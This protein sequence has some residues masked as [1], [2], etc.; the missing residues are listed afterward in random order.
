MTLAVS[1]RSPILLPQQRLRAAWPA[2]P[3]HP[4]LRL[5]ENAS[6]QSGVWFAAKDSSL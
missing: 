5:D 6:V 4:E 1:E 3:V 2:G